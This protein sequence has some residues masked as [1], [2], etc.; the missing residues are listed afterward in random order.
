MGCVTIY[1]CLTIVLDDRLD[2]KEK[3]TFESKT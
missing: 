3:R 1:D 2:F